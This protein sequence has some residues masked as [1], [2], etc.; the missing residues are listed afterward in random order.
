QDIGY[1][2]LSDAEEATKFSAFAGLADPSND[3]Y[4]YYLNT[5]G[6]ITS[7]YANYNGTDG[8]SPSEVSQTNRGSTTLPT[9][10]D[11]NRD[12]TMNTIDSYFEYE[13]P[14]F[15]GMSVDQNTSTIPGIDN[16][17]ITDVKTQNVTLQNG[18]QM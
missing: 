5:E 6:D 3:N 13:V 14:L 12:N 2:G 4:E 17:Y 16:D 11:V 1:D 10:E 8:N 18:Q 7:R 15:S 9:V